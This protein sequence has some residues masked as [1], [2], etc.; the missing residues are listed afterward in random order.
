MEFFLQIMIGMIF[1]AGL[2]FAYTCGKSEHCC[3]SANCPS[4]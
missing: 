2:V 1:L 3:L 4:E